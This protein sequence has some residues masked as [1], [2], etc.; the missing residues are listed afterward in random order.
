MPGRNVFTA[1]E[2]TAKR[3]G[4][5]AA[6]HQPRGVKAGGGYYTFSW[7]QWAETSREIA[8][9]LREMGAE[10]GEVVCILCETRAEFYLVDI[11]IMAAGAVVA[12]LYTAYPIPDL[13]RNVSAIRPRFLFVEDART[14]RELSK[15]L[16]AQGTSSPQNVILITGEDGNC[17]SLD[18]L[19]EL[20][21]NKL[22]A[23]PDSFNRIQAGI[24][25]SDPAILYLTSGATGEPK[26]SLTSH[27]AILANADMA[28]RVLPIDGKDSMLVFLPSAHIAQRI[29]SEMV[30]LRMGTP[31]W[32]SENLSK[33]PNE[34][35]TVRPTVLLAPPRVWE[36]MYSSILTELKKRPP[37]A[38]KLFK[39][40]LKLGVRSA[41]LREAGKRVPFWLDA[42]VRIANR[43]VFA[44]I[45][46]RLGGR[47][48][49][50]ASGAA[51]LGQQLAEFY[52]GIGLPLI[53]GYGLTEAG[54]AC[55]NPLGNPRPGSIGKPLP[56]VELRL[57]E[58]G[59]LQL[60]TPCLFQGYYQD[61]TATRSVMT[62]DGWFCTGDIAT[63]DEDGYWYI[64]GRKKE[65]IVSSNGKKI[66]PARLENL[67]KLE[68][69]VNQ[70]LLIGDKQPYVTALITVN[71]AQKQGLGTPVETA[72][73][74]AIARV[75]RQL[76]D[77]EQIRRFKI[78]DS[79]FSIERGELTPTMKIRRTRVLENYAPQIAELYLG[80]QETH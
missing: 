58:D 73:K 66:Y 31:V 48:R 45:R 72:V 56:G 35:R 67:F 26:M 17:T 6:L 10:P 40:S 23:D 21:R 57:A 18:S 54:V 41:K 36:R 22:A 42:G 33:L 68:P 20:G 50:A 16:V 11:G 34:L 5:A 3:S 62:D 61:D 12:A 49:I 13:A 77:F 37:T 80:R 65:L 78:L 27:A 15:A 4:D 19:R 51:P 70:I 69:I 38:Q 30:P 25:P 46:E 79:D 63:V 14:W 28:P 74:E 64:T 55:L 53:E 71:D 60:R 59:E 2:E 76:A 1:L 32:F 75:N 7:S 24:S 8:L 39:A 47:I 52:S 44:K 9:G 29:V 43:L